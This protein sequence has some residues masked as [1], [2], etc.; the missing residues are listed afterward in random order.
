MYARARAH[1][2]TQAAGGA[3]RGKPAAEGVALL[4]RPLA[5]QAMRKEGQLDG[6]EPVAQARHKLLLIPHLAPVLLLHVLAVAAGLA[7]RGEARTLEGQEPPHIGCEVEQLDDAWRQ[8]DDAHSLPDLPEHLLEDQHARRDARHHLLHER[9]PPH[10]HRRRRRVRRAHLGLHAS[11]AVTYCTC[12]H[13]LCISS[14]HSAVYCMCM[15]HHGLHASRGHRM[16][17][18]PPSVCT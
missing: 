16:H 15:Y 8:R 5:A 2:H 9:A 13:D 4:L 11:L 3:H 18:L 14:L 6:E 17:A 7:V 12:I 1:T 10:F